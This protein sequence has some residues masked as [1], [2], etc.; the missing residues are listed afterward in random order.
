VTEEERKNN[1]LEDLLSNTFSLTADTTVEEVMTAVRDD[2]IDT[3]EQLV[4]RYLTV[5]KSNLDGRD[6]SHS[7]MER[8]FSDHLKT[9]ETAVRPI[10]HRIPE[11]A[12]VIDG[13]E[14]EPA[15]IVRFNDQPLHLVAASRRGVPCLI[16]FT[17]NRIEQALYA[18]M[19]LNAI[20]PERDLRD[21]TWTGPGTQMETPSM[22]EPWRYTS[23]DVDN[24]APEAFGQVRMFSDKN[25]GGDWF[26]LDAGR[27]Y[28][29]LSKVPRAQVLWYSSDWNDV[30]SSQS[31]TD[32]NVAYYQ[33][34]NRGGNVL[35][36]PRLLSSTHTANFR[37]YGWDNY[38]SS[39]ANFGP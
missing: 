39:V 8:A 2:G 23:V 5:A 38:A 11:C 21:G 30:I 37:Q 4:E 1:Q 32:C 27:A 18:R 36:M 14:V 10:E 7:M 6:R 9:S 28:L 17:D 16:G 22:P 26:W 20:R 12:L 35:I 34:L 33:D 3:I 29:R 25:W 24:A 19:L 15:D 31:W 13:I